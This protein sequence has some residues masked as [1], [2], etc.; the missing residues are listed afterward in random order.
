VHVVSSLLP[1]TW[2]TKAIAGVNQMEL[3]FNEVG[4]DVMMLLALS[5][6]YTLAGIGLGI[7]RDSGRLGTLLHRKK[8]L[9]ND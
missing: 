9:K 6:G 3:P 4:G 8:P 1:S 2:A 5:L 7:L